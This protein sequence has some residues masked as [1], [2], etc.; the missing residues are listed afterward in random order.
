MKLFERS[1]KK[2]VLTKEGRAIFPVVEKFLAKTEIFFDQVQTNLD[3]MES[4]AGYYPSSHTT[5]HAVR[6]QGGSSK[7]PYVPDAVRRAF[8]KL[9]HPS[10]SSTLLLRPVC[11]GLQVTM[12]QYR[13]LE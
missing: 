4:R 2:A 6:H 1:N 7:H 10:D 9:Y 12:C 13:L 5:W 3:G 11:R 8:S